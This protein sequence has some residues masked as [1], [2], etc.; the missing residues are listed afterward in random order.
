MQ[1]VKWA[2]ALG[3]GATKVCRKEEL[4]SRWYGDVLRVL[5]AEHSSVE[6]GGRREGG[7]NELT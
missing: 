4:G 6:G 5:V 7:A 2:E 1:R 3:Q